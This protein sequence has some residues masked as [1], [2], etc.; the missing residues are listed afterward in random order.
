MTISNWAINPFLEEKM[1]L[2]LIAWYPFSTENPFVFALTYF[3]QIFG[4][5]MSATFNVSTDTFASA[6]IT[7]ANGQVQR[8]GIQLKKVSYSHKRD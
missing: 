8:L 1:R 2:P 4:I 7:Q 6:M 3:Y 5:L